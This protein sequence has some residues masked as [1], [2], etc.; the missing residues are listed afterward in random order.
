MSIMPGL[1]I[2]FLVAACLLLLAGPVFAAT[3]LVTIWDLNQPVA[4]GSPTTYADF[5]D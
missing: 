3:P 2:S 4:V 1:K 5:C